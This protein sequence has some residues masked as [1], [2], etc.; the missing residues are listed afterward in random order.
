MQ[1]TA[2][3]D[4]FRKVGVACVSDRG[5]EVGDDGLVVPTQGG[6]LGEHSL[7]ELGNGL[8]IFAPSNSSGDWE[9]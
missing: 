8:N 4:R 9:S 1:C 3:F 6:D 5:G 7:E 2:Y